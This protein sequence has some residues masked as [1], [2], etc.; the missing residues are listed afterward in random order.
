[1]PRQRKGQPRVGLP[2]IDLRD[3]AESL[4]LSVARHVRDSISRGHLSPG[5]QLEGEISL[6][7]G[8]GVSRQTMRKAIDE[9][10]REGLLVRRHGAGTQVLPARTDRSSGLEGLFDELWRTERRPSTEVVTLETRA[11]EG[12][13]AT[14]LRVPEG[15]EVVYLERLRRADGVPLAIMRNWMPA[16]LT[17]LQAADL[18]TRGLYEVLRRDGVSLRLMQ[19]SVGTRPAG[20]AAARMLGMSRSSPVLTVHSTT[21]NDLGTPVDLGRHD[22]NGQTYRFRVTTVERQYGTEARH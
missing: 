21:Y 22:Y 14:E 4:Y 7:K 13:V 5:D 3:S 2:P 17:K 12:E 16:E 11:A 1:M 6:A 15:T 10:V 8:L 18:E 9:L 19:Q 20:A